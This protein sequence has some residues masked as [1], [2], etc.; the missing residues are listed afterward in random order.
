MDDSGQNKQERLPDAFHKFFWDVDFNE[1]TLGK[2]PDFIAVRIL[3]YG[4]PEALNWLTSRI[5]KAFLMKLVE[6]NRNL[7]PK[8]RN[9]WKLILSED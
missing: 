4:D 9:F 3:N 2:F 1:L 6:Y 7:N 5:D 8:T